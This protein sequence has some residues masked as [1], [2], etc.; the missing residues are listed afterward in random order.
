[1]TWLLRLYPRPWR[2]RYG[3]EVAAFLATERRTL[4][5]TLDL[6]AGAI[7]ARLNPQRIPGIG[8]DAAPAKGERVMNAMRWC[9]VEGVTREDQWRGVAW[10]LGG[11][12]GLM[13]VALLVR[14]QAGKNA[15]TEALLFS[16]YPIALVISSRCTYLK[17]YSP[18]AQNVMIVASIVAIL[19][20]T[21]L[22][23]WIGYQL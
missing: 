4:R 6:I 2:A 12:L 1:M 22:A 19:A 10:M 21:T 3:D 15:F 13:A 5:L 20:I 17:R 8:P 9:G 11:T 14:S 23:T 16:S 7:D 18:V